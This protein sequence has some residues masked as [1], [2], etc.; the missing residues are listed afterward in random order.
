MDTS[1]SIS[2]VIPDYNE[3]TRLGPS[4]ERV[5]D[6][7]RQQ[8]WDA[9]VIVVD[10]GSRDR[11]ADIVREYAQT[12]GIVRLVQNPGNRG[13]GYSVRNGVMN[14]RGQIILFTPAPMW[15]LDRA[16]CGANYRPNVNLWLGRC[17]GEPSTCC[18]E[19]CLGS[20][21]RT[22]SAASRRSGGALRG[23]SFLCKGS[24]DGALTQRFCSWHDGQVSR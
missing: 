16:G 24:S 2:I 22:R 3:E 10:D 13:K 8:A 19:W 4:L 1:Y 9:E 12:N 14:A 15:Q 23:E 17:W 6:F 5:L 20:T 18:C 11:T 21:S 7:V